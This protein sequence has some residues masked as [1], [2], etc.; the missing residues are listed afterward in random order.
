ML[1][2]IHYK[3]TENPTYHLSQVDFLVILLIEKDAVAL[4]DQQVAMELVLFDPHDAIGVPRK[5]DHEI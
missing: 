1:P 2:R 5:I 4:Q 3:L